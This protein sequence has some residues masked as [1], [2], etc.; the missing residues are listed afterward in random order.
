M[1]NITSSKDT[2]HVQTRGQ[3]ALVFGETNKNLLE[4]TLPGLLLVK[5]LIHPNQPAVISWTG[6]T[7]TY[8]EL[9]H[10]SELLAHS[11]FK[12][13]VCAGDHVAILSENCEI[14]IELL[15]A[16]AMVGGVSV[17]LNTNYTPVELVT[18]LKAA[19]CKVLFTST[20]IGPRSIESSLA[21]VLGILEH[22]ES[23]RHLLQHVILIRPKS[24]AWETSEFVS[25]LGKFLS[26]S[27]PRDC[28]LDSQRAAYDVCNIQ[29]TSGT[30]GN[31][32]ASM[33]SHRNIINN[34]QL[35]GDRM[36]LTSQDIICSPPPLF[37]CF[38]LV[39]GMLACITH[40]ST[41][42]LPCP[43]FKADLVVNHLVAYSC[44]GLLGVPTMLISV[45][46]E[47]EKR[48]SP[49]L[50]LRT[51]IAAG[52]SVPRAVVE[53]M[54]SKFGFQ[55]FINV[56]GMTET[57]PASF[58][59]SMSDPLEKKL[60]TVGTILPHTGAKVVDQQ[61]KVL[62][63]GERGELCTSGY[64]LQKGY[65]KN[66]AKTAEAMR[67]EDG[68][69]W[70]YT[71]DEAIIDE[72]GYC[73]ITGRIKDIIIRG[74]ENIAPLEIEERLMLRSDITLAS[75]V[76]LADE[77]YGEAVSAFVTLADGATRPSATELQEFVQHSLGRHKTPS[78]IFWVGRDGDLDA[79]PTTASGKLQK[80][81]LRIWGNA[82]IKS[83]RSK[84]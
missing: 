80:E 65:Y 50:V 77:R 18:A 48:G 17:V 7:L 10:R 54:R 40:G 76:G 42:V 34:A 20:H 1:S 8:R 25:T 35:I 75:V 49:P 32:K 46:E 68:V 41:F 36:A 64:N 16:I 66:E 12:Y 79:F 67:V 13:G 69:T 22:D 58:T 84:L 59:T 51:G 62:R 83:R 29:F 60:T 82:R 19:D 63:R 2:K 6:V 72:Q 31:P 61:G 43:T 56:Y 9:Y 26:V 11:L 52:A 21:H 5:V 14:Y 28:H 15:F 3:P 57:A 70:M 78:H 30:T 33:L 53:R 45:L 81:K 27:D 73:Y 38:G 55:E 23:F 74:G 37:H 44:T 24:L 4:L 47:H 71:G 39:L